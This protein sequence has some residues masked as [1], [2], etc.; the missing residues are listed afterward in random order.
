M[1]FDQS[2]PLAP[3]EW[4]VFLVGSQK[5]IH[6]VVLLYLHHTHDP[7]PNNDVRHVWAN[8]YS[9]IS[10][11]SEKINSFQEWG[12]AITNAWGYLGAGVAALRY[13]S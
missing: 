4:R 2:G 11:S 12:R 7:S 10:L 13:W 1:R 3:D 5:K 6:E 9:S 8:L